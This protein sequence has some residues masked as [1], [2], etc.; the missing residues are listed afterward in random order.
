MASYTRSRRYFT[1]THIRQSRVKVSNHERTYPQCAWSPS[2]KGQGP[3]LCR[4]RDYCKWECTDQWADQGW[5]ESL[6]FNEIGVKYKQKKTLSNKSNNSKSSC[7]ILF[8]KINGVKIKNLAE[9]DLYYIYFFT[10]NTVAK[11]WYRERGV[12][13]MGLTQDFKCAFIM[14]NIKKKDTIALTQHLKCHICVKESANVKANT[15]KNIWGMVQVA[16]RWD[17]MHQA[18]M[19]TQYVRDRLSGA[20]HTDKSIFKYRLIIAFTNSASQFTMLY[21]WWCKSK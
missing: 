19:K 9:M 4:A 16:L 7:F 14:R 17:F 21:Q 18:R 11:H 6:N 12:P 1:G 2:V 13:V 8:N 15:S 10:F 5:N 20:A 3:T